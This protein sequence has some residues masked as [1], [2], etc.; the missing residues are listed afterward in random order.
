VR[1]PVVNFAKARQLCTEPE[2]R[3]VEA[4]RPEAI[5]ELT[6]TQLKSKIARARALRDKWQ[7]VATRQRRDVQRKQKTR[8]VAPRDRSEEKSTLFAAVLARFQAQLDEGASATAAPGAGPHAR[9]S[10]EKRGRQHRR[11]RSRAKQDLAEHLSARESERA[12][13]QR[14]ASRY[15]ASKPEGATPQAPEQAATTGRPPARSAKKAPKKKAASARGKKAAT[16]PKS[17]GGA[18]A[19]D[20]AGKHPAQPIAKRDRI[21]ATG[22]ARRT[23]GHA[24]ARGQRSQ[25]RRDRRG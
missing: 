17:R 14:P 2:L 18:P 6:E 19:A 12:R 11:T 15:A 1:K 10:K 5:G 20:R 16:A 4:S 7:D 22:P 13:R 3:L 8:A 21:L 23:R 9:P 25:A 24:L